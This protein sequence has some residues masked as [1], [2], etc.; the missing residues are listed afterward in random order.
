[1]KG[2]FIVD[3]KDDD[4]KLDFGLPNV[5]PTTE[6]TDIVRPAVAHSEDYDADIPEPPSHKR[7]KLASSAQSPKPT[8]TISSSSSS[9][10]SKHEDINPD[11]DEPD[12]YTS[13]VES[14]PLSELRTPQTTSRFRSVAP[15]HPTEGLI[16]VSKRAFRAL[17]TKARLDLEAST[18]LPDAFSPSRRKGKREYTPGGLAD[19]VRSWVLGAASEEVQ[20]GRMTE[21]R[22]AVRHAES[23]ASG[24]V[25]HITDE[26]GQ[27]WLLVGKYDGMDRSLTRKVVERTLKEGSVIIR[28]TSTTW[29]VA[30]VKGRQVQVAAHWDFPP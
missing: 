8:I 28:G 9:S 5:G 25:V 1:M 16:N 21:R 14:A 20:R 24:R 15:V 10:T 29:A 11:P 3:D 18:V 2:D 27:D 4:G 12:Q 23:D 7:R 26:D 19:T 13:D 6:E 22:L 17:S 30:D